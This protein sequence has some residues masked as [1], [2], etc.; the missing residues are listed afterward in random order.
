MKNLIILLVLVAFSNA[1]FV[2]F[3]RGTAAKGNNLK[4]SSVVVAQRAPGSSENPN[5]FLYLVDNLQAIQTLTAEQVANARQIVLETAALRS[6]A[7]TIAYLLATAFVDS[8]LIPTEETM[9]A[10]PAVARIQK[11]YFD[12]G[13]QGRGYVHFT[14]AIAYKRFADA[15]KTDVNVNPASALIPLNAAKCLAAGAIG[16]KFT[17]RAIEQFINGK[18]VDFMNAR[19]AVNGNLNAK[20]IADLATRIVNA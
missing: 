19:R 4:R 10:N 11:R 12:L 18:S 14:G 3:S 1:A 15:S 5:N 2:Q 6:C 7:N 16:G 17:G 9:S 8:R 13:F 20:Q